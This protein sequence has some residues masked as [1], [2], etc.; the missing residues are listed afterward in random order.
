L[1]IYLA[2]S[3][4]QPSEFYFEVLSSWLKHHKFAWPG[5]EVQLGD[6]VTAVVPQPVATD[7]HIRVTESDVPDDRLL[8]EQDLIP[9]GFGRDIVGADT[10]R[11][12][13]PKDYFPFALP[14]TVTFTYTD[15]DVAGFDK[16]KLGIA[17]F[18]VSRKRYTSK[19]LYILKRT[20]ETNSITFCASRFGKY[21]IVG[22]RIS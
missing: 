8:L 17:R 15:Q 22:R 4:G 12:P 6:G 1:P 20:P 2:D 7:T 21:V 13:F 10:R 19:D 16:R 18:D 5:K 3:V 11:T 14:L 9:L